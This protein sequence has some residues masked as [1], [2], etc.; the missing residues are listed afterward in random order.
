MERVQA[1]IRTIDRTTRS[2]ATRRSASMSSKAAAKIVSPWEVEIRAP[3]GGSACRRAP[4]SSPPVPALRAADPGIESVG[5][6]VDTVW[7]LREL[8]RR[9]LVLGGGPIGCEL[10]QAFARFGSRVTLVEMAPRLLVREDEDVC[11]GRTAIRGR[12]YRV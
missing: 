9:L 3:D 2:N 7:N 4:S 12:R 6:D 5:P 10:A 11:D 8:P 1:V